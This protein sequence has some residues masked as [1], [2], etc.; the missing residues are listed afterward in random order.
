MKQLLYVMIGII[1]TCTSAY[2]KEDFQCSDPKAVEVV[3][4]RLPTVQNPCSINPLLNLL[5]L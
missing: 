5:I 4:K 1:L 3:K 2:A